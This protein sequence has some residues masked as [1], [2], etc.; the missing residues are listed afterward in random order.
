MK[1]VWIRGL[2]FWVESKGEEVQFQVNGRTYFLAFV[3]SERR[4]F[5]FEPTPAGVN[6]IPVY[7]DE[8]AAAQFV[9]A[10]ESKQTVLN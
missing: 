2:N 8:P 9:L 1:S 7:V 5:V 6:R 3:E 4:W 10:D